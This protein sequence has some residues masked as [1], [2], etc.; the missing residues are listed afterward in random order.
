[1][2]WLLIT[3]YV[4]SSVFVLV[5]ATLGWHSFYHVL[6]PSLAWAA[7]NGLAVVCWLGMTFLPIYLNKEIAA[8]M[9]EQDS[10]NPNTQDKSSS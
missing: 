6:P 2:R 4:V 5:F 3:C 8:W 9:R 10:K 1:M 7:N